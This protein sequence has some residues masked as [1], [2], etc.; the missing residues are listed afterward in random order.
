MVVLMSSIVHWQTF[1][2]LMFNY[3]TT[4]QHEDGQW[5]KISAVYSTT[6]IA[7]HGAVKRRAKDSLKDWHI[8]PKLHYS[9]SKW[10]ENWT[11]AWLNWLF[12]FKHTHDLILWGSFLILMIL[13]GSLHKGHKARLWEL[14]HLIMTNLLLVEIRR[15]IR[16]V[17]CSCMWSLTFI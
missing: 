7:S 12:N 17:S 2:R 11:A 15:G 5:I 6:Q 8:M 4:K 1:Q 16:F 10:L 14:L 3:K 9:D 13:R